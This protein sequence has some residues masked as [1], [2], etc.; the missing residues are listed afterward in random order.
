MSQ[1]FT[2]IFTDKTTGRVLHRMNQ[3]QPLNKFFW[4]KDKLLKVDDLARKFEMPKSQ[5]D[6]KD[7][8]GYNDEMAE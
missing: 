8:S 1:I 3:K 2:A 6:I 4:I 5:I 7:Y